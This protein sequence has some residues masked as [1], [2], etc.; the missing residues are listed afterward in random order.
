MTTRIFSARARPLRAWQ[1]G[2]VIAAILLVYA[3]AGP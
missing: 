3:A 1:I 2:L